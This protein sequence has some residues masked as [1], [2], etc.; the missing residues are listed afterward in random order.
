MEIEYKINANDIIIQVTVVPNSSQSCITGVNE[1]II[2]LKLNSP[3]IDG[4]A[5]KEVVA[6]FSKFFRITLSDL[7]NNTVIL[8]KTRLEQLT[9]RNVKRIRTFCTNHHVPLLGFP[10]LAEN[11]FEGLFYEHLTGLNDVFGAF[12]NE[13]NCFHIITIP[14]IV[15]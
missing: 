15:L 5:N 13:I 2:R 14:I 8:T 4:R 11:D 10:V 1:G 9:F 7:C 6:F 3:P 12:V